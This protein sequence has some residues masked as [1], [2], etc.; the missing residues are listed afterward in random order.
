VT[1]CTHGFGT[2]ECAVSVRLK[3]GTAEKWR[4]TL[5]MYAPHFQITFGMVSLAS[6]SLCNV[7]VMKKY[8]IKHTVNEQPQ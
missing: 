2:L 3:L 5:K 8:E 6:F 4:T 1:L 7:I